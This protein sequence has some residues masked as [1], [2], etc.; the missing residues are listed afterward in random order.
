MLGVLEAIAS[1]FGY[2]G[3]F[4]IS[5]LGSAVPFLP[6]PYLLVVVLLSGTQN[7]LLLGLAAG[8]GGAV[9]K[10]TSYF[11]GRFGYS[12]AGSGTKENVDALHDVVERYGALGVFIFA[13]S[14]LPDDAYV[15]PMG[16]ARLPFWRFFAANLAGKLVLSVGVA[17]LGSAYF[18]YFGS[19][20][21]NSLPAT[22]AA[23][24]LTVILSVV[25]MKADW[26]VAV[27]AAREGGAGEVLTKLPEILGLKRKAPGT[28]QASSA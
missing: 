11:V 5:A 8:A 14:P 23:I 25:L 4:A 2:S 3:V 9:G 12:A 16:I 6:V 1:Q 15:I 13:V 18:G 27:R 28:P 19:V 21:G 10:V 26:G 20:A 7:P 22:A 24:V 17:Y